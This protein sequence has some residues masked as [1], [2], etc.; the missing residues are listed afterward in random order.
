MRS[1]TSPARTPVTGT[2]ICWEDVAGHAAHCR[3]S[4]PSPRHP[5]GQRSDRFTGGRLRRIQENR[6]PG[7]NQVSLVRD[8]VPSRNLRYPCSRRPGGWRCPA[9][10]SLVRRARRAWPG[11][12]ARVGGI[13]R[14]HRPRRHPGTGARSRNRSS[15]APFTKKAAL[16]AVLD[17]DG[18]PPPLEI[19][20]RFVDL[21]EARH[22]ER[23]GPPGSPRPAGFS[24]PV[25]E[26]AVDIG[27][28][29]GVRAVGAGARRSR[30][31]AGSSLPSACRSCRCTA[32]SW[33]RCRE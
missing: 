22:V 29:K 12:P 27:I 5:P 7:E 28:G 33:R 10:G 11:E 26:P 31:E 13:E 18:N 15:G 21:L 4:R 1:S 20:R 19:E 16:A 25:S 2:P 14:L 8:N 32:R 30:A 9:P 23:A 3:R 17:Q 24:S 6:E